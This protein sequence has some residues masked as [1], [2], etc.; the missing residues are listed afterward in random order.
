M[1]ACNANILNLSKGGIFVDLIKA[2]SQ[3]TGERVN[4]PEIVGKELNDLRFNLNGSS[5]FVETKGVCVWGKTGNGQPRAGIR[6][7]EISNESKNRI[8]KYVDKSI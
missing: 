3:K 1:V 5:E 7:K 6:F 8:H 4:K 2:I